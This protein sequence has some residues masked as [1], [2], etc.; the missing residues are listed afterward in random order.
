MRHVC[1]IVRAADVIVGPRVEHRAAHPYYRYFQDVAYYTET[2]CAEYLKT[3]TIFP[4][5]VDSIAFL[6]NSVSRNRRERVEFYQGCVKVKVQFVIKLRN[7]FFQRIQIIGRKYNFFI[8]ILDKDKSK[9]GIQKY[10]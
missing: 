3:R 10:G 5:Y 7:I 1:K 9:V 6:L 2:V 4:R 8:L